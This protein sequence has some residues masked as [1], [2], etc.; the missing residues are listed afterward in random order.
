MKTLKPFKFK[1]FGGDKGS[2]QAL[3][4]SKRAMRMLNKNPLMNT[5]GDYAKLTPSGFQALQMPIDDIRTEGDQPV[6][7]PGLSTDE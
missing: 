4:P 6:P 3:L 2:S 1:R 5:M 7:L